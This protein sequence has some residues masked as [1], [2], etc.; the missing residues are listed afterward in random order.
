M[1]N[2][3]DTLNAM[4]DSTIEELKYRGLRGDITREEVLIAY[5]TAIDGALRSNAIILSK[6]I[7]E[8]VL[9]IAP[10]VPEGDRLLVGM[11]CLMTR[12]V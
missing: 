10:D 3:G 7:G 2:F 4:L 6:G 5:V 1:Q 9:S 12:T 8:D 11:P